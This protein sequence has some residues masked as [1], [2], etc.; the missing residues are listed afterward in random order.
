MFRL[1]FQKGLKLLA[2]SGQAAFLKGHHEM[3][4]IVLTDGKGAAARI[5]G[6]KVQAK[7]QLG[8]GGFEAL[9]Q[10]VKGLEFA[11]L[12]LFLI[13]GWSAA[14]GIFD[15]LAGQRKRQ[16]RAGEQLGFQHRTEIGDLARGVFLGQAPRAMAMAE[17]QITGAVEAGHE[18]ALKAEIIQGFHADEPLV[19]LAEQLSES[20]AADMADKVVQSFGDRQSLLVGVGQKSQIVEDGALEVAQVAI[21]RA[22]AA[23]TQTK[24][25]QSPPAQEAPVIIV[26]RQTNRFAWSSSPPLE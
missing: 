26:Q 6:V 9:G 25:Q 23:Q 21:G 24:E 16:T 15:E 10:P 17:T 22:A 12:F 2:E 7:P 4:V 5:E 8:E 13:V 14:G 19:E 3:P 18:F 11:I 20:G 1:K